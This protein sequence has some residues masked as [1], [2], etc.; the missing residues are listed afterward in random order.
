VPTFHDGEVLSIHLERDRT[1]KLVVYGFRMTSE[2]DPANFYV[3]DRKFTAI[4]ELDDIDRLELNGFSVQNIV[5]RMSVFARPAGAGYDIE[6][7]EIYGIGGKIGCKSLR[8]S[9]EVMKDAS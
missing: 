4:F 8:V 3:I 5:G 6:L 2:T 1:S 7:D 9:F